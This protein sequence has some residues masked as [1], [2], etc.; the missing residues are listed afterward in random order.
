MGNF[1]LASLNHAFVNI[2]LVL[3]FVHLIQCSFHTVHYSFCTTKHRIG[4]LM[5]SQNGLGQDK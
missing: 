4:P 1:L 5:L 2:L 3:I